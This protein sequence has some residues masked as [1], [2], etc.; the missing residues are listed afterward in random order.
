MK[1]MLLDFE[2]I[3]EVEEKKFDYHNF[4]MRKNQSK[5]VISS[6]LQEKVMQDM[7][8]LSYTS[9]K[10]KKK[11]E[12]SCDTLIELIESLKRDPD[13]NK[14][15]DGIN[16]KAKQLNIPLFNKNEMNIKFSSNEFDKF[17]NAKSMLDNFGVCLNFTLI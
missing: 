17:T 10:K 14:L 2:D 12:D 16:L 15:I 5:S 4:C 1:D 8:S 3:D 11:F 13:L 6:E 7:D 9:S